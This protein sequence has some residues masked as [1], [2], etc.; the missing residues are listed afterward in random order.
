MK[1]ALRAARRRIA[2]VPLL[3]PLADGAAALLSR[4][5]FRGSGAYW[6][7]R[8]A[9]G[10]TS[11]AGSY[12]NLATFK[13][14]ILNDFVER[15]AIGTVIEFGCGDGNQLS[16]ARYPAYIGLDVARSAIQLCARRF[17]GDR[18]KSFFVYDPA[19]FVDHHGLFRAELALS[20][21][22]LYHLVEDAV[23]DRYMRSLFDAG[24]RFVIV[25]SSNYDAPVR[26]AAHVRHRR[27]TDW[28]EHQMP[29]WRLIEH[30]P[31]RYPAHPGQGGGSFAD[32]FIFER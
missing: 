14:E 9:A 1:N 19:G 28:V 16:L 17:D 22:V 23:F 6:E 11:G 30:L 26:R 32:F 8:Y 2:R 4:L 7:A 13:A 3:A 29:E 27:F 10:S 31:N 18:S 20:L 12:G 5:R 15:H 21:D 24:E 25:Y